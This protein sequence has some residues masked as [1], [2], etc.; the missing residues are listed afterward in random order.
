MSEELLERASDAIAAGDADALAQVFAEWP[1]LGT[2]FL[3]GPMLLEQA[4]ELGQVRCVGVLLAAGVPAE[5]PDELGGTALT[6]AAWHGHVEVA[7]MLLDAGADPDA[8]IEEDGS[9]GDP[10]ASGRCA[11][12]CALYKGHDALI[13][14][15]EPI[16]SPEMRAKAYEAAELRRKWDEEDPPAFSE[17]TTRLFMAAQQGRLDLL[18]EALN[19]SPDV[20][21]IL[22]PDASNRMLGS[23]PLSFAAGRGILELVQALLDAGA[24]PE[25]KN[26]NGRT[27]ADFAALNG[28]DKIAEIL[29]GGVL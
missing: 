15:L 23:T 9:Y 26:H 17:A 24:D 13:A 12:Y 10:R 4:A 7:R 14:L 5:Y 27:A 25:L 2:D 16:T 28:H 3:D 19:D 6:S 21:A 18:L 29:R 8:A 1:E 11:L 22:E 20:N